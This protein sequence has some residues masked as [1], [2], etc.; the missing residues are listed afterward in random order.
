[1]QPSRHRAGCGNTGFQVLGAGRM[2]IA[3]AD[4]VFATPYHLDRRPGLP[5]QD[6]RLVDKVTLGFAPERPAKQG[7]VH[8]DLLGFETGKPGRSGNNR[9]RG[10]R[11]RPDLT[12]ISGH[13]GQRRRWLHRRVGEVWGVVFG[14][15]R[16][17]GRVQGRQGIPLVAP[18]VALLPD[19]VQQLH[20]VV[21]GV[22][23][24]VVA[25][26]PLDFQFPAPL[27]RRPGIV[28]NHC[29]TA[30]RL[31][32]SRW[33]GGLYFDHPAYAFERQR[34]LCIKGLHASECDR[35]PCNRRIFHPRDTDINPV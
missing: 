11:R 25:H 2:V 21:I 7:H 22:I 13:R 30:E 33:F 1:M 35:A 8:L 4:I 29:D 20:P 16:R 12:T 18:E 31:E 32:S 19:S 17:D 23:I 27:Q 14:F 10:L 28:G 9:L 3:V 24:P 34:L 5:G 15:Q 26:V 6:D